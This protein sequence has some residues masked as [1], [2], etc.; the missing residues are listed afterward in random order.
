MLKKDKTMEEERPKRGG[1]TLYSIDVGSKIL[2][3]LYEYEGLGGWKLRPG[4]NSPTM[5]QLFL[6]VMARTESN[7]FARLSVMTFLSMI[8]R[9]VFVYEMS[10]RNKTIAE[11]ATGPFLQYERPSIPALEF[12]SLVCIAVIT[13]HSSPI[14][15]WSHY[16]LPWLLI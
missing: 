1:I 16:F 6:S 14:P 13:R 12:L 8:C 5:Q 10:L 3:G 2:G 11:S 4:Q 9:W 7:L 15:S